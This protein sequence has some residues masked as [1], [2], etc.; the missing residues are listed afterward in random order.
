MCNPTNKSKKHTTS[1]LKVCVKLNV[2]ILFIALLVPITLAVP[3]YV[4]T[5]S[6]ANY[7]VNS[8]TG[9]LV[10]VVNSATG[11][12][13][14]NGTNGVTF[15]DSASNTIFGADFKNPLVLTANFK[16]I[17]STRI[18][19]E[20]SLP[21][22]NIS[23]SYQTIDN[24][25]LE[26]GVKIIRKNAST[27]SN[28]EIRFVWKLN[29]VFR[30][31]TYFTPIDGA[32]L[33][34]KMRTNTSS[35]VIPRNYYRIGANTIY[36]FNNT[37]GLLFAVLAPET[38]NSETS[39]SHLA[40]EFRFNP[41]ANED[42]EWRVKRIFFN[43]T[44]SKVAVFQVNISIIV[45]NKPQE[46]KEKIFKTI[47]NKTKSL[48]GD[49]YLL[50]LST[51]PDWSKNQTNT[52]AEQG[53]KLVEIQNWQSNPFIIDK[54]NWK[55]PGTNYSTNASQ[56]NS[57]L[58]YMVSK[59][60][61]PFL[62]MIPI[63]LNQ[64]LA[65]HYF[66][67]D[68]II[69]QSGGF[70]PF[71]DHG[72][73]TMSLNMNRLYAKNRSLMI[74]VITDTYHNISG[75]FIDR[76][77]IKINDYAN[78]HESSSGIR[79]WDGSVNKSFI[80]TYDDYRKFLENISVRLK[81]KNKL[82]WLN[83]VGSSTV[84]KLAD[85]V[86]M[87]GNS[88]TF[89]EDYALFGLDK[90]TAHLPNDGETQATRLNATILWGAN[91]GWD[92][93]DQFT[94]FPLNKDKKQLIS[95]VASSRFVKHEVSLDNKLYYVEYDKVITTVGSC[96]YTAVRKEDFYFLNNHTIIM[97]NITNLNWK[98][99][100]GPSG[101]ITNVIWFGNFGI[102]NLS[103]S[104]GLAVAQNASGNVIDAL[105][106][107][108]I[109]SSSNNESK[110]ID[111][112]LTKT[113]NITTTFN[114]EN[115]SIA[116]INYTSHTGSY[117]KNWNSANLTCSNNKITL[118]LT[119][120]EPAQG[121][122]TLRI[123]YSGPPVCGDSSCNGNETCGSC[124]QDCGVCLFCGDSSCNNGESCSSCPAD[125]GVCHSSGGGGGSSIAIKPKRDSNI[126]K[127]NVTL[128]ARNTTIIQNKTKE[129]KSLDIVTP[130][131]Q[132][133]PTTKPNITE[134]PARINKDN[135][136]IPIIAVSAVI[137]AI[138]TLSIVGLHKKQHKVAKPV[139]NSYPAAKPYPVLTYVKISQQAKP[140]MPQVA[141]PVSIILPKEH[142]YLEAVNQRLSESFGDIEPVDNNL[143]EQL[144][145]WIIQAKSK[146]VSE[147]YIKLQLENAGWDWHYVQVIM[148]E[149]N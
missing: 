17:D 102:Y 119:G 125:C 116:K 41:T 131:T 99:S 113:V 93:L 12:T 138:L 58:D 123:T 22:Y 92:S 88:E 81:T 36:I 38:I 120:V 86:T 121:S 20:Q 68:I 46:M 71:I 135:R 69:N 51:Y 137:S 100:K 9:L 112:N 2:G 149:Q 1:Y 143:K 104:N 146:D 94:L 142:P 14:I 33:S 98:F 78:E 16:L 15:S 132:D 97:R 60:L 87:D 26:M 32:D 10:E 85:I 147:E 42:F 144:K 8:T 54:G 106:P 35:V 91:M 29:P 95:I 90:H 124:S 133:N 114:V 13:Y 24:E 84:A 105:V 53:I 57:L 83:S 27:T 80:G 23:Y 140:V 30:R 110:N 4:L 47:F 129:I 3:N 89:W 31:N 122:N 45:G 40:D 62:Y 115:C 72:Y 145:Q 79:F 75:I 65:E 55:I 18:V 64:T 63:S 103:E 101:S 28:S 141:K 148:N 61:H 126:S 25:F 67:S 136:T 130:V 128:S 34:L 96:N 127:Q 70:A 108:W 109:S 43:S 56:L 73:Y 6:N 76:T 11:Q 118:N 50:D 134:Q 37:E 82:L 111:S 117:F 49:W 7:V 48:L 66:P 39:P 59:G 19:A 5:T 77:E 44:S 52:L 21:D 139:T 107:I 74:D